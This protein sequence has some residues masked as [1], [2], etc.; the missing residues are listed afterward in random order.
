MEQ[1]SELFSHL[2]LDKDGKNNQMD[3][4][5]FLFEILQFKVEKMILYLE[6]LVEDSM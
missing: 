6:H 2:I 5:L 1:N 3:Y 4:Q